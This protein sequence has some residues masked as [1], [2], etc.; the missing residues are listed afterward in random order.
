MTPCRSPPRQLRRSFSPPPLSPFFFF[1]PFFP[2]SLR[3]SN[4]EFECVT[5]KDG[6]PG[7]PVRSLGVGHHSPHHSSPS[8]PPSSLRVP[9]SLFKGAAFNAA[10]RSTSLGRTRVCPWLF[11]F[12]SRVGG[13]WPFKVSLPRSFFSPLPSPPIFPFPSSCPGFGRRCQ[14]EQADPSG[15]LM[16][17]SAFFFPPLSPVRPGRAERGYHCIVLLSFGDSQGR[18]GALS[19]FPFF[20]FERNGFT[21]PDVLRRRLTAGRSRDFCPPLFLLS[22]L[23]LACIGGWELSIWLSGDPGAASF[24]PPH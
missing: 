19:L 5:L 3:E 2:L 7:V 16:V 15:T 24:S 22:L 21:L 18:F 9:K 6:D 17:H 14:V 4:D 23:P 8:P 20:F 10:A 13:C 12:A 1:S 11:F